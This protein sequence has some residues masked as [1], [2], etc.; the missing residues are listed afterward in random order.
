[1]TE[2]YNIY[3]MSNA[4]GNIFTNN[5]LTSFKNILPK[6]LDLEKNQWE[7]GIVKFGFHFNT[8]NNLQ[9]SIVSVSTDVVTDSL[10]SQ[11]Y[12]TLIYGTSLLEAD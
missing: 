5:S 9:P 12:S 2:S 6:N 3:C 4:G 11:N 7:I 8:I 1:M 10:S